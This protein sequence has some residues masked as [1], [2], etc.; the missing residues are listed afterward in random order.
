[1]CSHSTNGEIFAKLKLKDQNNLLLYHK[2]ILS[3]EVLHSYSGD[4]VDSSLL[5]SDAVLISK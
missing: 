3:R 4:E 5:G 1:M 2:Q